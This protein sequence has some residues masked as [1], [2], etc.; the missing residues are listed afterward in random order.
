MSSSERRSRPGVL[1]VEDSDLIRSIIVRLIEEGGEFHVVAEARTGFE[2]IHKVH[3]VDPDIV[4]LDLEM[5]DL[6][7]HDTL[8]YIMS[9]AP[10]PVVILSAHGAAGAEP[11]L[12]AL[13]LGAVEVVP[14]PD[15]TGPS[16]LEWLSL[17]LRE[18]LRASLQASRIGNATSSSWMPRQ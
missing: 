4:T 13:D 8:G 1:V 15:G 3:E 17:R 11:A 10:R 2:A 7:G 5:P 18:A 16:E 6:G 9:E 14:K 12:R